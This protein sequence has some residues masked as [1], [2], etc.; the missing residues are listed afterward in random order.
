[1]GFVPKSGTGTPLIL[2]ELAAKE[3]VQHSVCTHRENS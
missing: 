3:R 2:L 1:M